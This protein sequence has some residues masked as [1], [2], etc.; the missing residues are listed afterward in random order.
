MGT[1]DERFFLNCRP[2]NGY[3]HGYNNFGGGGL[4]NCLFKR[5]LSKRSPQD[6][7]NGQEGSNP[8]T[9][10]RFFLNNCLHG[11]GGYNN[12]FNYNN[13]LNCY[14][15]SCNY[16]NC[17]RQCT[18]CNSYGGGYNNFGG[19]YNPYGWRDGGSNGGDAGGNA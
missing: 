15:C 1:T 8:D 7:S 5:S 16:N 12:G 4:T 14:T 18:K 17:A 11:G 19:G 9:N 13:Q 6:V 10:S 2:N 3:N